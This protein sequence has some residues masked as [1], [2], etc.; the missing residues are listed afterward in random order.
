M[1]IMKQKFY[2]GL[3]MGTASVGWAVT[4]DKYNIIKRHGKA[5]WGVRLFKTANTA[6]ERRTFRAARRRTQRRKQRMELLQEIFGDEISK[7]DIGFYQ[8]M[9]ESKYWFEDKRDI[10]GK[11]PELPYALFVD[12]GFTDKDYHEQFPTIF[13]LRNV[14]VNEWT[15]KYDIRLVYLAIHHIIKHRGH[16]LFEGKKMSEVTD[17]GSAFE[18]FCK[19][20][21]DNDIEITVDEEKLKDIEDLLKSRQKSK[22][23]K[24]Q[25]LGKIIAG[26]DKQKK[27][28]AALVTGCTIKL[29]EI[30]ADKSLDDG[31]RNKISFADSNYDEYIANVEETLAERFL[32][33]AAGKALY[34]WAVLSD[35]LEGSTYIS[36]AKVKIYKKHGDDLRKLKGL[37]KT[38]PDEYKLIFGLPEKQANYSAYIGMVKK[39][40]KKVPIDKKC[41]KADFYS[42]LK[43]TLNK[44]N[45]ED[46]K[47]REIAES[48]INEIENEI[49]LPKQVISDN[50][51]IPYQLHE[52]ELDRILKN[53]ALYYPFLSE[54]DDEGYTNTDK[55]KE[56]FKFRIP[57]Y[58]GPLNT[59][60]SDKGGN[61]WAVRKQDGKIYP[62]NFESKIDA[63]ES[64]G[65]F[66]GRMTN[67]CTY[68][69]GKDVLPKESLLYSKFMVLNE[70]NNLRIDGEKVSVEIKQAVYENVFKKYQRVTG[71][72]VKDF[73]I[74]SGIIGR[75]QELS[76]FDQNFKSSLKAYHDIKQ[77]AG[78]INL[79]QNQKE[80]IIKDI[81]VFADSQ[82]MLKKRLKIKY[83]EL[84][85]KQVTKL[86]AKKYTG[87]GRL[88]REFLEEV[89]SVNKETG[90]VLNIISALWE[91]NENLMQLLSNKYDY[92]SAIK[93][94]N[95]E[96]EDKSEMV[97]YDDVQKLYVSP[98]VKRPVWQTLKIVEEISKIMG[99]KPERIFVEMAREPGQKGDVK[100]SRKSRLLEKYKY[101]KKEAPEIY[102]NLVKEDDNKLRSDKLFLYY[103]QMGR[104]MYSNEVIDIEDLFTNRYDIDH[105]YPQSKVM[106]DSLDNRVLVK[107]EL[108]SN[109][110][111]VFPVPKEYMDKAK[112]L[113]DMLKKKD[114]ISKEK[115]HRLT[116]RDGFSENE[117]SGF[118]A[119]QLVETR[120]S[121]KAV[122]QLLTKAYPESE[123]VY[124]KANAVS[125]FRHKFGFTKVR[126][127]NDYHH[128]KDAYL[129]IV[130]GNTY[131][132]KFTKDAAW[133]IRNN[134]G[135]TYNLKKM[136]EQ[137]TVSRGGETAW[138]SGEDGTIFTVKRVMGKNNILFTRKAYEVRGKLFNQQLVK[139][140]N[141]QIPIKGNSYDDR[142]AMKEK[143]GAYDSAN[144]TYFM[145]VE[146]EDKKGNKIRTLEFVPVYLAKE[147]EKSEEATIRYCVEKL[148]LKNPNIRIRKIKIDSLFNVDGF[149]M[150]LSGRTV[151]RLV[152]KCAEQL[153]LDGESQK[154]L[155][156]TA[157]VSADYKANKNIKISDKM[158]LTDEMLIKL[159]ELLYKKLKD[160]VYNIRLSTQVTTLESGK[161]KF[162]KLS[163]LDKCLVIEEILHLFQC[164]SSGANL[165][166]IGGATTA[167]KLVL[168]N[169]ISRCDKV[170]IIN[171]SITGFYEQ[172]IDLKT[173]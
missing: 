25:E 43:K 158:E 33:I 103:T 22:T 89:E 87:W 164:Q 65:K 172:V 12:D 61:S 60:H 128:A 81:T 147:L 26:A 149:R 59:Y 155:K 121:T 34:D 94:L 107:R 80:D 156:K 73:L 133:F 79:S 27:A 123:I 44:I 56:L 144:G 124:A 10:N 131:Y 3:D 14:L 153:I 118:I 18:A 140:G 45:F 78:D 54:K 114:L 137:G 93:R 51:V 125:E 1:E 105:I 48:I 82:K 76:G 138:V 67:K 146:S 97:T 126:S 24:K 152:F 119:R 29:S 120:Q 96:A 145:L 77:I 11:Q 72:K 50:G 129:N 63:E 122:T 169:E 161:E 16:F 108:N 170:E 139:K 150:H 162:E 30:F 127:I 55:I 90:E 136:F 160:T 66:I 75:E 148:E 20:A 8:R 143:Y 171:Q 2:V 74:R 36:E 135:R 5:L 130:V 115:Y 113:W 91:T 68:L 35:I 21:S 84:S 116:R 15:Q 13:H 86:A 101:C 154:I 37:L 19:V 132:V 41:T 165:S 23:A 39:N 142:L 151:K 95:D 102:E 99:S 57:Y 9:K 83:P 6:E 159:Y 104:C 49:F 53:A 42:F 28:L 62:W 88:S 109:K 134:P 58:V 64:A 47:E 112:T 166:S 32:L 173:I 110:T 117:L 52:A 111:D 141:G 100:V 98:A 157:K 46:E 17:F 106:D 7:T 85:D 168:N 71:K 69:I 163:L 4:D 38:R 40:G 92:L 167:G 70:L 31:E